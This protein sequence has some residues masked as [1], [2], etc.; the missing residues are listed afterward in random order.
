MKTVRLFAVLLVVALLLFLGE[1]GCR[2]SVGPAVS[3]DVIALH[4]GVEVGTGNYNRPLC[5]LLLRSCLLRQED[6]ELQSEFLAMGSGT[7]VL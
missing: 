4:R 2:E 1:L 6:R 3:H 5:N 7:G